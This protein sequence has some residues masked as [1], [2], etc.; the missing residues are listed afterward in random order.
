MS[1]IRVRF[2]VNP[3]IIVNGEVDLTT[4]AGAT[5][6]ELP[7]EKTSVSRTLEP[8]RGDATPST[9]GPLT[10]APRFEGWTGS[11]SVKRQAIGGSID[12]EMPIVGP[13][14]GQTWDD[15]PITPILDSTYADAGDPTRASD[16]V[17]GVST[18]ELNPA[19]EADWKVGD[20]GIATVSGVDYPFRV[21]DRVAVSGN[22]KIMPGLDTTVGANTPVRLTRVFYLWP[23][24]EGDDLVVEV[25]EEG[26]LWIGCFVRLGA[27]SFRRGA[28]G[29]LLLKGQLVVG[30]WHPDHSNRESYCDGDC[31]CP[32]GAPAMLQN[33][34]P[35]IS[36]A[37]C[38]DG[39][40]LGAAPWVAA[41]MTVQIK[42]R[43]GMTIKVNTSIDVRDTASQLVPVCETAVGS[44]A[45]IEVELPL[46]EVDD[47]FDNDTNTHAKRPG[48]IFAGPSA[49]GRGVVFWF[50]GLQINALPKDLVRGKS[51]GEQ[52][53]KFMVDNACGAKTAPAYGSVANGANAAF[54]IALVDI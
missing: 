48:A 5:W 15:C 10:G 7:K 19:T 21:H 50:G 11:D 6:F 39:G 9:C 49:A 44:D 4:L 12:F 33:V 24:S 17:T 27:H 31:A 28:D 29:R 34:K 20:I 41:A 22:L 2:C 26:T 45:T 38:G 35:R 3:G 36:S 53:L 30:H 51:K 23:G 18:T 42:P 40:T 16:T 46:C 54:A 32:T 37:Y 25:H 52:T 43:A 8:K 13:G 14:S 47:Q 1:D